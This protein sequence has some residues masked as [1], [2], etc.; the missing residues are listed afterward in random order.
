MKKFGSVVF[1]I[2]IGFATAFPQEYRIPVSPEGT[3]NW[4]YSDLQGNLVIDPEY[5]IFT[6]FSR[7]GSALVNDGD[8]FNYKLVDRNG[9][10][11]E[12][13]LENIRLKKSY[14]YNPTM[15]P[16]F[17]DGCVVVAT[18]K[19][20]GCLNSNGKLD[21]PMKYDQLT[22]FNGGYAIARLKK[23]IIVLSK[24]GKEK[25]VQ[26]Q[27]IKEFK[28][29]S[30]GFGQVEI[31]GKWGLIDT[32]GKLVVPAKFESIGY[33]SSGLA[34]AKTANGLVG[35]IDTKGNW[36]IQPKFLKARDFD[37][38]SGLA[39]VFIDDK[40]G[41]VDSSG[42]MYFFKQTEKTYVFSEGLAIGL[43]NGKHGFINNNGDWVIEPKFD[44][45]HKFI[46]GYAAIKVDGKWGL[47]D[48]KGEVVIEPKFSNIY[49][50]WISEIK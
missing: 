45:V 12:T 24:A 38:E 35:F 49:S 17:S 3:R 2:A 1:L 26:A 4:G 42:E 15:P 29:F 16:S 8:L 31:K 13:E 9:N 34:W 39:M 25:L 37:A 22:S 21:I 48:K 27:K 14:L 11:I 43:K 7:E 33:F 40:W 20:F 47:M 44:E 50:K 46:Q 30:S 41:Y 23:E 32:T 18:K 19:N 6:G 5:V 28:R 36:V 10:V